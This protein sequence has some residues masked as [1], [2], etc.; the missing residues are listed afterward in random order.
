M[1]KAVFTGVFLVGIDDPGTDGPHLDVREFDFNMS[2]PKEVLYLRAR[3][4]LIIIGIH[5]CFNIL[6]KIVL[7]GVLM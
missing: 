4:F 3:V 2:Y 1:C 5:G 7:Q 6:A